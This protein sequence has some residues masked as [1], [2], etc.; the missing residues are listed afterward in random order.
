MLKLYDKAHAVAG[1]ITQYDRL[2]IE[3]TVSTGDKKLSFR[4][5]DDIGIN[6][7]YYIQTETDEYVVKEVQTVSGDFRVV[8]CTLNLEELESKAWKTFNAS[9]T[10]IA[11]AAQLAIA[12]TGWTIGTSTVA[13]IRNAGILKKSA[14]G[15][16]R[17]LCTAFMCEPVFDTLN[18]TISF[19]EQTG[20]DRGV[21]FRS[22]LNLKKLTIKTDSYDLYTRIIPYGKDDLDISDVNNGVNYLDNMQYSTKVRAYIWIDT[23]YTDAAALKAD[24]TA[25]LADLSKPKTCYSA[26]VADLARMSSTYSLL[27]FAAGDTIRLVDKETGTSEKQRIVKLTEYPQTPEQN[28]VELANT[29]LTW[30]DMQAKLNAA[31]QIV[32]ALVS[33]DGQYNGT[34]KVSDILHFENGIVG[35]SGGSNVTLSDFFQTTDGMLGTLSLA[36]GNLEATALTA[37]TA[38]IRYAQIDMANVTKATIGTVL[39]DIGLITSATI[40]QGHVT[41]YLDSVSVNADNITAGTLSVNRLLIR[42]DTGGLV[43][44]LNNMGQLVS[45]EVDT[46]DG[47]ILTDQTIEADKIIVDS[48]LANSIFAQDITATGTITGAELIAGSLHSIDYRYS[49]GNYSTSGMIVDLN[50]KIYRT[51]NTAILADGS[52]Y[53][54]NGSIGPW[55]IGA[56]G[57]YNGLTSF[58]GLLNGTYIGTDGIAGAAEN[59]LVR[60]Q[61]TPDGRLELID[62]KEDLM[63]FVGISIISKF[64]SGLEYDVDIGPFG[65]SGT[66]IENNVRRIPLD[67]SLVTGSLTFNNDVD[68]KV[69]ENRYNNT[70]YSLIR[71]H[72]NGNISV[73]ASSGSLYLGYENTT[74]INFF[75]GK[76]TIDSSGNI[77]AINTSGAA[78]VRACRSTSGNRIYIQANTDGTAE[79]GSVGANNTQYIIVKRANNSHEITASGYWTFSNIRPWQTTISGTPIISNSTDGYR[80]SLLSCEGTSTFLIQGQWRTTGSTYSYKTITIPSSDIRMKENIEDCTISAL[81]VINAIRMRQFDWIQDG[82]HQNI[83]VVAD[84]LEKIDSN[85]AVGGGYAEDG[86]INVKSVNTFYLMGYMLKAIQ[87]LSQEVNHLRGEI[88]EES[89]HTGNR[90]SIHG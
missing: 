28:T 35:S 14:L 44:A 67:I 72:N 52:L 57:I 33:T 76:A 69:L 88:Y 1:N 10:T 59:G 26:Q 85:L 15:V 24:A 27:D 51:P 5:L 70:T 16:I 42:G 86:N 40:Q 61:L 75:N 55:T 81:P 54:K 45:Q 47:Y 78:Y 89:G 12:G 32:S 79:L 7:E 83:G 56:T 64:D 48:V 23:N 22:D 31:N 3:T 18:K 39:A 62:N 8:Y 34:I 19:Y 4:L 82:I 50:N 11:A 46:I 84:E 71:N 9:E 20:Q 17:D 77:S 41:G 29:W 63:S 6:P 58:S 21:Y 65:I 87:E 25:Y 43:Y 66:A 60:Y 38:D 73:S 74:S 90:L 13:K 30:A 37:A 36:V 49:S 53:T 68:T 80:V 2:K